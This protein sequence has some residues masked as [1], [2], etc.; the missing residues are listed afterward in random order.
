MRVVFDTNVLVAALSSRQGA[1]HRL[2]RLVLSGRVV[3]LASVPLW[4]EYE[5]VLKRTYIQRMHGLSIEALD[6]FLDA[7]AAWVEPVP[8]TYRWRPQLRDAD[9]EM[10]FETA[11]NG[12]ADRLVTFN[13]RDFFPSARSFHLVVVS[14]SECLA[15]LEK[16]S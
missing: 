16:M 1:S 4:L 12:S 2:L 15:F 7:L 14:P 13:R 3:L 10:V 5:S 6:R 9:D 8:A 11:L